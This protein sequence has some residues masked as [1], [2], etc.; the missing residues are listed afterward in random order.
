MT[1]LVSGANGS[2]KSAYAEVLAA[3]LSSGVLYYIATMQP[4]GE[5]GRERVEKHR[6]QRE[7]FGFITLE[8]PFFVSDFPYQ[9]AA[10]VLLE[11]VSN[12]L[13]NSL[14]DGKENICRNV[15]A[16]ITDSVFADIK[17]LCK[18]CKNAVL[19]SIGGLRGSEFDGETRV[20]TDA[21]NRL[22]RRISDFADAV[23]T[24]NNGV[25]N[26]DIL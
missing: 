19:V 16:D 20:F 6:K 4:Y 10:S 14:F 5:E 1:V 13:G 22:N 9:P 8:K 23:V 24:M 21:L 17:A 2:G 12:L 25:P 3:R 7:K 11:D 15:N 18:K 26:R